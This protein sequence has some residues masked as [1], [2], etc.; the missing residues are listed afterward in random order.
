[1][2]PSAG[3]PTAPVT[4][5]GKKSCA[6]RIYRDVSMARLPSSAETLVKSSLIRANHHSF[7]RKICVW[8]FRAENPLLS[9]HR[10]ANRPTGLVQRI[11][12]FLQH[13]PV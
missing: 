12:I 6:L 10:Y 5:N 2:A 9:L 8:N 11:G 4:R 7:M 3:E 13:R 1:M